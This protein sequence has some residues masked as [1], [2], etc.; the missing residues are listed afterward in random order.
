MNESTH[1][2]GNFFRLHENFRLNSL[3]ARFE[4][5][6]LIV[7]WIL[8]ISV[9]ILALYIILI[10]LTLSF[11]SSFAPISVSNPSESGRCTIKINCFSLRALLDLELFAY[12]QLI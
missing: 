8:N 12:Y 2:I 11:R 5:T 7:D 1:N 6:N 9:Y 3:H 4:D 10:P